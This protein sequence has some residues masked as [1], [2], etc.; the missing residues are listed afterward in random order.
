MKK[1]FLVFWLVFSAV[2]ITSGLSKDLN[3]GFDGIGSL[4]RE[5]GVAL[6]LVGTED[7][8]AEDRAETYLL[9]RLDI[10]KEQIQGYLDQIVELKK[11]GL[12]EE[13]GEKVLIPAILKE[14]ETATKRLVDKEKHIVNRIDLPPTMEIAGSS[15]V[16]ELIKAIKM[17]DEHIKTGDIVLFQDGLLPS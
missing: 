9:N 4:L 14:A 6:M 8:A 17:L 1:K 12:D 3:G 13:I 10:P 5:R 11:Q 7:K 15:D 2:G 16:L